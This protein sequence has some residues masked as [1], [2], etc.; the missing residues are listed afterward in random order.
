MAPARFISK[1]QQHSYS[2]KIF[3]CTWSITEVLTLKHLCAQESI[4]NM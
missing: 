2:I 4:C 1:N 3:L